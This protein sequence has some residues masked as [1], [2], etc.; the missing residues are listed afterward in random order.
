VPTSAVTAR[1]A[2]NS[3]AM[4]DQSRV[5]YEFD[6]FRVDPLER[7]ILCSGEAIPL[8]SKAFDILLL[9][10]R[11][12]GRLVRKSE[13]MDTIWADSFVGEHNL[14]V[15]IST[16][17]KVLTNKNGERK[18]IETV[19][20]EGYRF[21]GKVSEVA[22]P[23]TEL[24]IPTVE[25]SPAIP[26][27]LPRPRPLS[28]SFYII[29][30]FVLTCLALTLVF[31]RSRTHSYT[32]GEIRSLA[33]LP[34]RS[35]NVDSAHAYL[36]FGLADA[37]ITKLVRTGQLIVRP[38]SAVLKYVDSAASPLQVG[39]EQNVDAVLSGSVETLPNRIRIAI[40][41]VRVSDGSLLRADTFEEGTQQI[42]EV[43]DKVAERVSK[44]MSVLFPKIISAP[45]VLK[46]TNNAEA[47]ELY[48]RGRYFWSTRTGDGLRRSI[49]YLQQAT[50]K[51]P[52]YA[53]AYAGLADS[54]VLL[55]TYGV[56]SPQ[57]AYPASRGAALNALRLDNSLAEAH[58]ALGMIAF[59]YGW[60]WSESE[61]EFQLALALNPND[62]GAETW[63]GL[64]LVAM[65]RVEEAMDLVQRAKEI[66]PLSPE[67]NVAL[68]RLYYSSRQYE[69]AIN[70]Y[71]KVIELNP[72]FARAHMRLGMTYMAQR[73]LG[74]SL[75]EFEEAK[76]LA[77][78]DP[79]V[80][81][82]LGC[83]EALSGNTL[84]A[85]KLLEGLTL[86]SSEQY[87][88]AFSI[89]L[90]YIGLGERDRALEWLE[91]AYQD[92]SAYMVYA[93]TDPLLDPLRSDPQFISILHRMRLL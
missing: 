47:H 65:G 53:R 70:V 52:E 23:E 48:L 40:Q 44:S 85:Q 61:H 79:Y 93:K 7:Q 64:N 4:T 5:A 88:P 72:N 39:R 56:E 55:A 20:K 36:S 80:D 8:T 75:Y 78:D 57:K 50:T 15:T 74:D 27:V 92:R 16:L 1:A 71:R 77:P 29:L 42:L 90:V 11:R 32:S 10:I 68:G 43:E 24:N 54:Y 58:A 51:D 45:A 31:A 22:M 91:R 41:L 26:E 12:R 82:L 2:P 83:A 67:I 84:A 28:S 69:K 87:V 34:L 73:A 33:V 63:Y 76:R 62:A 60:N 81:G 21:V 46:D 14:V 3:G 35:V 25:F 30:A 59:Y 86:R 6:R 38:T 18:C 89:V 49:D 9:L 17:R 66:D 13:I 19:A 37:I